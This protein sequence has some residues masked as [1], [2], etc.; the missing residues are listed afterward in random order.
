MNRHEREPMAKPRGRPRHSWAERLLVAALAAGFCAGCDTTLSAE[1]EG[2]PC[3]TN[4]DC[5]GGLQCLDYYIMADGGCASLGSEC[6]QPCQVDSDCASGP[7]EGLGLV[8][9]TTCGAAPACEEPPTPVEAGA[10][11]A[12]DS[13]AD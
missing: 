10:D 4:S 3:A 6:L 1:A 5:V 2:V 7:S 11:A 8:C 9:Q 12:G 13:A